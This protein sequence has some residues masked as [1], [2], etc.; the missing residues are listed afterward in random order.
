MAA[1]IVLAVALH[2]T[3][4]A[5]SPDGAAQAGLHYARTEMV[6]TEGPVIARR[7]AGTRGALPALL[8]RLVTTT[9]R[10]DV[11]TSDLIRRFGPGRPVEILVLSGVY[12][13][14]PPD[15]GV[16]VQGEALV[17]VD[18]RTRRVLFLTT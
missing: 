18:P 8:P 11:N 5:S 2:A 16:D 9:L 6:W 10:H 7:Q 17:L 13:S 14:L 1:C 4:G 12:N 15:E 3:R